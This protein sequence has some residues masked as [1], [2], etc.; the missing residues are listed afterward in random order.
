MTW[1]IFTLIATITSGMFGILTHAGQK[2]MGDSANGRYKAL[3]FAGIGY[4]LIAIVGSGVVL[5]TTSAQ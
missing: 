2:A 1:L 5:T 3:L 4:S